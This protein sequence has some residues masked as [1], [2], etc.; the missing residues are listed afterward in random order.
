MG[1]LAA[2]R[3][4]VLPGGRRGYPQHDPKRALPPVGSPVNGAVFPLTDC[5]H[6]DD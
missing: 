1:S 3:V 6:D 5:N 4:V 2:G